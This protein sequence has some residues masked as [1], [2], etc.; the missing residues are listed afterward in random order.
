MA[1]LK[2]NRVTVH[3]P[4]GG[5]EQFTDAPPEMAITVSEDKG[6]VWIHTKAV[7]RVFV[8]MP[9]EVV[10]DLPQPPPGT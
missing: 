2:I 9:F 8:G 5:R 6:I 7:R 4:G 1:T 10:Y 3:L